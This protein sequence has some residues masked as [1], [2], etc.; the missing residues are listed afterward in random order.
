MLFFLNSQLSLKADSVNPKTETGLHF[1][2]DNKDDPVKASISG[3]LTKSKPILT[4]KAY[5]QET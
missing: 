3:S 1:T 2:A 5:N 4:I